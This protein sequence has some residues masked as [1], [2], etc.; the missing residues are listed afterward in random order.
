MRSNRVVGF[1]FAAMLVLAANAANADMPPAG[2]QPL[3]AV[4]ESVEKSATMIVVSADFEKGRWEI[5]ACSEDGKTCREAYI[6]P[7]SVKEQ[8]SSRVSPSDVRAPRGGKTASQLA[9]SLEERKLGVI[10]E[11]EYEDAVWEASIRGDG[12][13]AKLYL[14]PATG[15]VRRCRG[16][17]CPS[18]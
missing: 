11:L 4:L 7:V 12:V 13:R 15:D 2:S 5:V 9:R 17:G 16:R 3:S 6:D 14:D 10:T 8:R 18:R 1:M